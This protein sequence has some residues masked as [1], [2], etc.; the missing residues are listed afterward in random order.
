MLQ[1][2]LQSPRP[3]TLPS[4]SPRRAT[5]AAREKA[6]QPKS[7]EDSRIFP[8]GPVLSVL[9]Q[10][11]P[12]SLFSSCSLFFFLPSLLIIPHRLYCSILPHLYPDPLIRSECRFIRPQWEP[13]PAEC[14]SVWVRGIPVCLDSAAGP[15]QLKVL[16]NPT[17]PLF[18]SSSAP[19]TDTVISTARHVL[20]LQRPTPSSA[21]GDHPRLAASPSLPQAAP[22]LR[23]A[24]RP[25]AVSRSPVDEGP[26]RILRH[27][28]LPSQVRSRALL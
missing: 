1:S 22:L 21:H 20:L 14:G 17:F 8:P 2:R 19:H 27:V 11:S 18:H 3:P 6:H 23:L 16:A 12:P 10:P 15:L 4:P 13:V 7:Q 5:A 26:D 9:P 24:Q 25:Q 28:R